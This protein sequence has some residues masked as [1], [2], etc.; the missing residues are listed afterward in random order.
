ML[1]V[2]RLNDYEWWLAETLEQAMAEAAI[3]WGPY[4]VLQCIADEMY[5]EPSRLTEAA[6]ASR[7]FVDE[8]GCKT[9]FAK[10]LDTQRM[11]DNKT[12]RLFACT[13]W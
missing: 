10:E 1:H 2:F 13:E 7:T 9:T 11:L 8:C 4:D 3:Q 6:L 5:D 12:P